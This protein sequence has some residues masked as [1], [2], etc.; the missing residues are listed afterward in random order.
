DPPT[1]PSASFFSKDKKKIDPKERKDIENSFNPV[2]RMLE[3]KV[4]EE[5]KKSI[6]ANGGITQPYRTPPTWDVSAENAS[7]SYKDSFP[8]ALPTSQGPSPMHTPNPNGQPMPHAHQLPAHMQQPPQMAT[9]Q[10]RGPSFFGQPHHAQ[11]PA[12]DPRMQQFAPGGSV[13]GS[14]RFAQG[15][16][17]FGGQMPPN[18]H[19][20]MPQFAGQP[21]PG[22][23]MSPSMGFRQPQMMPGG[24]PQM[25][26]MMP[27]QGHG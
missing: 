10:Q 1:E 7:S 8:K 20:Q 24:T 15:Q 11:G 12:F 19:M 18:M 9:P 23:G 5:H 16:M 22:Y 13:Q 25:G 27:M 14:P 2:K 3:E 21:M 17:A 4:P 26:M 6:A